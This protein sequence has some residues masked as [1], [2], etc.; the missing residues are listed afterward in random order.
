MTSKNENVLTMALCISN[1]S[2]EPREYSSSNKYS[3]WPSNDLL[4]PRM[5]EMTST[6]ENVL[7]MA[8]CISNESKE[9]REYS[10]NNKSSVWSSNDL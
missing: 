4:G 6:N 2:W 1:E 7:T 9:S 5:I 10:S 8:L 3:V